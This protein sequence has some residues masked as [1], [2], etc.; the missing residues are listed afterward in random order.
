MKTMKKLTFLLLST[1]ATLAALAATAPTAHAALPAL[2]HTLGNARATTSGDTLTV[3]TGAITQRWTLVPAGLATTSLVNPA[4]GKDWC[5][6]AG[7]A[8]AGSAK[9]PLGGR[10][11]APPNSSS[12]PNPPSENLALPDFAPAAP[13]STSGRGAG[14][15]GLPKAN[16]TCDWAFHGL[17]DNRPAK[18]VS[19]TAATDDDE[20]FATEHIRVLV[21]FE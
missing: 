18:L 16:T 11:E 2:D 7:S 15:E 20:G 9:I 8:P 5:A 13:P 12:S 6:P 21:E 17:L 3:T 10:R 1:L 14:G 4:T 19:L